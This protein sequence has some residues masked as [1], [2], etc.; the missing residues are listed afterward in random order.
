MEKKGGSK[1][2][3][4][5]LGRR[6]GTGGRELQ[7]LEAGNLGKGTGT[8]NGGSELGQGTGGQ[9]TGGSKVDRELKA[10]NWQGTGGSKLGTG[11]LEQGTGDSELGTGNGTGDR[12]LELGQGAG[13]WA[14]LCVVE[15]VFCCWRFFAR[16]RAL[17][18]PRGRSH[19]E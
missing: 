9:G 10:G 19:L 13:N 7:G 2:E 15:S 16:E 12:E 4:G 14:L 18:V 17:C 11:N 1:L 6:Q 5:N 8:G 3:T